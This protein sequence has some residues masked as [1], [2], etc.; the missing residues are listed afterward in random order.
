V[1]ERGAQDS[2]LNFFLGL[3]ARHWITKSNVVNNNNGSEDLY[4]PQ[5][6]PL[7]PNLNYGFSHH[8]L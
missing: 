1:K 3:P 8:D 4:Q 5:L 2:I 7:L 6:P